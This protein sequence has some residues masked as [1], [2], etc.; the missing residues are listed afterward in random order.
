MEIFDKVIDCSR[1]YLE[2][3]DGGYKIY[4]EANS[5]EIKF[6]SLSYIPTIIEKIKNDIEG[7]DNLSTDCEACEALNTRHTFKGDKNII[8]SNW[9]YVDRLEDFEEFIDELIGFLEGDIDTN[10]CT[11]HSLLFYLSHKKEVKLW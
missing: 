1:I 10:N 2:R 9:F 6:K 5:F 8:S 4:D 7:F 11:I 3:C